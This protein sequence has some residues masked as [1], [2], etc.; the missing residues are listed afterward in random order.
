MLRRDPE[1]R[2]DPQV[3]LSPDLTA[4]PEDILHQPEDILQ[5][6][7]YRWQVEVTFAE[8]QAHLGVETQR[9]W[10]A[11]AILRTTPVFLTLCSIVTVFAHEDHQPK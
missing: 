2:F 7:R 1:N 4:R 8:V 9:P 3:R 6:F 11:K 10:S 5:W